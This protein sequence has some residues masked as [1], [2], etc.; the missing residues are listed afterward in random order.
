MRL[1]RLSARAAALVLSIAFLTSCGSDGT[2]PYDGTA[3]VKLRVNGTLYEY[4]LD[5]GVLA[6]FAGG[7]TTH[8]LSITG[9]DGGATFATLQVWD[10]SPVST[11]TYEGLTVTTSL[12][13]AIISFHAADG[14]SYVS[15]N[16]PTEATITVTEIT[17]T[18]V[19][20][21]FFGVLHA[22]GQPDVTVTEG[23]FRVTRVN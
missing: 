4:T 6:A 19:A 20:G 23:L 16:T 9:N 7:G 11:G 5:G 10:T 1:T 15:G 17:G 13:G 3:F 2:G 22:S 21:T 12:V 14:T 18:Q 8:S